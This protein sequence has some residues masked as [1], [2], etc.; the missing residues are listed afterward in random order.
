VI[1]INPTTRATEPRS[2]LDITDRR[3]ELAGN[4]S[5]YQEL[6]VIEKIDQLLA[7]G[8]LAPGGRY[9][10]V[11][12]R[13]IELA[14]SRSSRLRGPA[15]KL[16]RDRGFIRDLIAQGQ[17]QAEEFVT[18]LGFEQQWRQRDV[19]AVRQFLADDVELISFAPFPERGPVRGREVHEFVERLF[20]RTTFP[21]VRAQFRA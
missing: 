19:D 16:N 15:S 11:V 8:L 14:R 12:V 21:Q 18:A 1:Q 2:V 10:Q 7:E 13:V 20:G 4:L 6:H 9:K 3:N 5:L 17:R